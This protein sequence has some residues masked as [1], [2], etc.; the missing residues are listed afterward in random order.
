MQAVALQA[1]SKTYP[2]GKEAVREITLSLNAGE[3]FG[4]LGPNGAG[5]TTTVK[6]LTGMLTPTSGTCRVLDRDPAVEPEAVHACSGVVTEHAQ[7]YDT[8]SGLENLLFYAALYG[9][10]AAE[11]R[12]RAHSLLEQLE[13]DE[14]AGQKLSAYSTGM[15]QRLSLARAL[16][17]RPRVLFLDEPTS[18]L[19]PESAQ[20]VNRMIRELAR[21]DG[22]TV[23]LC[24]HQ[25]RYAQ[26]ICTRYGLIEAG[27]LL[28][29]GALEELR[30][31]VDSGAAL[32]IRA[33]KMPEGL[34]FRQT[35]PG[36]YEKRIASDREIPGIVRQ[37]VS[38]GGEIY[39]VEAVKPDLEALY[40]A[41]T[42]KGKED[43]Q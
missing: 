39:A 26:E 40:F 37:I 35:G 12:R 43:A 36:L 11:A 20:N 15:R 13:L 29:E 16:I 34:A 6:L 9:V 7:M 8:M 42:A 28:A 22:S 24:T 10:P 4:F 1:L 41:L 25:L 30:A 5:K 18:G 3:V 33:E 17:H 31:Q 32:R 38:G 19:D 2:G 27:R 14:A 23:F 21:E